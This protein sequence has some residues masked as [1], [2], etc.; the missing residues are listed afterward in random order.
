MKRHPPPPPPQG[1][2]PSQGP[3]T[4]MRPQPPPPPPLPQS[5]PT[6]DENQLPSVKAKQL[7]ISEEYNLRWKTCRFIEEACRILKLPRLVISS[8]IVIFQRFYAVHTFQD[9]D[10]FEVAVACILLAAKTEESPKKLT[11]VILEC[12]RLKMKS[13]ARRGG[14]GGGGEEILDVNGKEFKGLKE[15]TLLLER[16]ILHTI[17]FE[18]SI[19]H[20]HKFLAEQVC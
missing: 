6:F 20:P 14:G 1:P 18:L 12:Y 19:D 11:S 15:R 3:P 8:A 13:A 9:H 5:P 16:V 2:P 10:R 4:I 17:G 7:T